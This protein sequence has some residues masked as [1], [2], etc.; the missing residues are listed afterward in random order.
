MRAAFE[1]KNI[2]VSVALGERPCVVVGDHAEIEQLFLNLLMNAHEAMPPHG[3]LRVELATT[4]GRAV[5]AVLDT[6][7]GVP[8]ELLERVFEPFF[9]TKQRGSGL[10]LAICIA[11]A[12]KHD[13]RLQIENRPSG[14][15][16]FTVDFPLSAD[17][18]VPA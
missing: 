5:A 13:A 9:T 7:S 14:G 10:G 18:R 3:M 4:G 11:I 17:A 15:A 2:V 16:A 6:G 12:Q 8:P 1:E